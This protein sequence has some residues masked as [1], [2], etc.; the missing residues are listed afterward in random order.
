MG[1]DTSLDWLKAQFGQLQADRLVELIRIV[2]RS[3]GAGYLDSLREQAL[4]S[5][6]EFALWGEIESKQG[7]V[8]GTAKLAIISPWVIV[9]ILAARAE[10]VAIYNTPEGTG[11][12]VAGLLVSIIAYRLVTLMGSLS[13]PSRVLTK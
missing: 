5:R 9:A 2:H 12:L 10:N 4:R 13:R 7:W 6:S 3:G 1:L 8:S 11:V